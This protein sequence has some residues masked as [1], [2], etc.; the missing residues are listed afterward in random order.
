M[1]RR[2]LLKLILSGA[3]GHA[4]DLDRLLWVPGSKKIFI[5]S[6]KHLSYA[7]IIAAELKHITPHILQLFERDDMFYRALEKNSVIPMSY[8]PIRVPLIIKPGDK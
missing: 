4:L 2:E 6:G 1:N 7:Q 5:P 8:R 3:A